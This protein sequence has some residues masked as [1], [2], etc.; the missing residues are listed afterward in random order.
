M[1][2]PF[3]SVGMQDNKSSVRREDIKETFKSIISLVKSENTDL[4]LICGDLY[5]HEY[6]RKSTITYINQM[7]GEIPDVHVVMIPG[8][9][10][11][12]LANSY[13]K[14]FEWNSNVT[15]LTQDNPCL[16]IDE[17]DV[18]IYGIGF[19][20]FYSE[21]TLLNTLNIENRKSF[22]ILLAHGTVD[23]SVGEAVYNPMDSR[24][25]ELLGMDYI[26]LGHF[27]NPY[28]RLSSKGIYNPGSPEPLGFDETGEHGVYKGILTMEDNGQKNLDVHFISTA[29]RFYENIEVNIGGCSTDSE[30]CEII[31]AALR[32]KDKER[33][34]FSITLTGYV[35]KDF[36]V[37]C[38]LIQSMLSNEYFY[39]KIKDATLP[40]YDFD[41]LKYEQGLK[42][43]FI[44]KV[45]TKIE[46][47]NNEK[48]KA[49]LW[50]ALY[51]GLEALDK[52][53]I[54]NII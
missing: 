45:L 17:L 47:T 27:H 46:E 33:G 41:T 20:S 2:M 6:V 31:S 53:K 43:N 10:D 7:F 42:G 50:K 36:R 12:F 37:N 14:N 3:T 32:N 38:R 28:D 54:E 34:I 22:N 35:N 16:V 13:Y 21:G 30:V 24:Q 11:P 48:E 9:H 23:I 44:R 5:E 18:C 15:I 19:S 29:K 25:L 8:N 49:L 39:I 1:D 4:L 51:Y 40:D 52:G 26:A